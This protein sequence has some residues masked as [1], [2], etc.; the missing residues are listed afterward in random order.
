MTSDRLM[1]VVQLVS[2]LLQ[3]LPTYEN[4]HFY[5]CRSRFRQ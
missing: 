2:D 3:S 1:N 5:L 4:F